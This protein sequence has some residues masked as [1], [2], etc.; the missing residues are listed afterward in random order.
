[1]TKQRLHV[2]GTEGITRDLCGEAGLTITQSDATGEP[3]SFF[4]S[5]T[6][7]TPERSGK[8]SLFTSL[9]FASCI[10]GSR[11]T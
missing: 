6:V 8:P 10:L 1:M 4:S 2:F 5:T 3:L 11:I 7:S 9:F